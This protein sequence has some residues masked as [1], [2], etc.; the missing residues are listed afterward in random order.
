MNDIRECYTLMLWYKKQSKII[1]CLKSV[2]TNLSA[3]ISNSNNQKEIIE[4]FKQKS[5]GGS[6]RDEKCM[7]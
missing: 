6:F 5:K 3:V 2:K 4:H 7:C 1:T